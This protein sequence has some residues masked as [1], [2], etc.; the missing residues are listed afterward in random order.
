MHTFSTELNLK[1]R[2]P[3]GFAMS[4]LSADL[5]AEF[6]Q[7]STGSDIFQP[8]LTSFCVLAGLVPSIALCVSYLPFARLIAIRL[9]LGCV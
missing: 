8:Q 2:R 6:V 9:F 5:Q 7:I 4:H 1:F 3:Y